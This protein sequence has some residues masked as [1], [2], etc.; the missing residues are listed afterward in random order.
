MDLT[1]IIVNYRT[2]GLV[3]DCLQGLY[4]YTSN[5]S[6]EVIVVDN[7]SSDGLEIILQKEFPAVKFLQMGYNAGF[8]RANNEGIRHSAAETV[9]LLNSDTILEDNVI[10]NCYAALRRSDHVACGVQ[11]LN[12]D[13]TPQL[14]GFFAVKGGLNFLLALPYA[15]AI[16]KFLGKAL[17]LK[18]PN[19]PE[20]TELT[21][22]DWVNGAFLMVK[23]S[24]I[25]I[26]GLLDEDFFLYAEEAEWC[27]RLRKTGKLCI[28]GDQHI[29]H[30][31]AGSS[32]A[33]FQSSDK[34]YDNIFDKKGQQLM[35]SNFL[36]I[37]KEHGSGSF[38]FILLLFV[39]EIPFFLV[40]LLISHLFLLPDR[41]PFKTFMGYVRNVGKVIAL[42]DRIL[43]NKPW[44]YKVM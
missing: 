18:K 20:A 30:L 16:I 36:R 28:Y 25:A 35:L 34:T 23:Q 31:L 1:I 8:A 22:V 11:L 10:G 4:R 2:P 39:L 3:R 24:A 9:L 15:G 12:P 19:V 32:M 37:K 33:T 44:F 42:S 6:F 41:Y 40:L 43:G 13:R 21:E 5:I 27:S 26:A 17:K 38:I 29:V 14:S 7:D